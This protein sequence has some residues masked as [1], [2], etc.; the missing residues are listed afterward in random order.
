VG[1]GELKGSTGVT[2]KRGGSPVV[3][4]KNPRTG[5]RGS[6]VSGSDETLADLK[7]GQRGTVIFRVLGGLD[8]GMNWTGWGI[9]WSSSS[10]GVQE[11]PGGR[12][13]YVRGGRNKACIRPCP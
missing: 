8:R 10:G 3:V 6:G 4:L 1:A 9:N 2:S 5:R 12:T 13:S 11:K 7:G